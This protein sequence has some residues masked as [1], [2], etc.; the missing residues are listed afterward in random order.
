MTKRDRGIFIGL[1]VLLVVLSILSE[2]AGR[3]AASDF[4]PSSYL[5]SPGGTAALFLAMEELGIEPA[6][7]LTPYVEADPLSGPL[8]L[9]SP[10]EAPTPAELHALA[11]WVR[12]G[13]TLL[14][15]ARPE[16]PTLDTLG[17]RLKEIAPDSLSALQRQRWAGASAHP[18]PHLLTQ[19]MRATHGFRFAL[20]HP[21]ST[22]VEP[23]LKTDDGEIVAMQVRIGSGRVVVLGDAATLTN[24]AV[25]GSGVAPIFAR[26]AAAG[27]GRVVFDEYHHG[28][29]SGGSATRATLRFLRDTRPGHMLA[30]LA[31]T[32]LGLL[33]LAGARFGS[34]LPPPTARRR[35]PLEHVGALAEAYRRAGARRTGRR[36][37][38]RGLQR[39]LGR[40]TPAE[41]DDPQTIEA[42]RRNLLPER[43]DSAAAL[44]REWAKGEQADLVALT[45]HMDQILLETRRG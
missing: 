23:L 4:R 5:S 15:A 34:P 43:R 31:V 39:R 11:E 16:D 33:L 21:E 22:T 45:R 32:A 27:G 1:A 9:L 35:D 25:E 2:A 42:L 17:L 26:A 28:F 40:R 37:L 41:T 29:R 38:L 7:R 19:E 10:S 12:A 18:V 24:R 30:Q 36:L 14:Y 44:E 8:A 6:R 3:N 20:E 13:G